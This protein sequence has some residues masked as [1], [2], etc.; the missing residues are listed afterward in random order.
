MLGGRRPSILDGVG[1]EEAYAGL[2]EN[3]RSV[4]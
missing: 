3:F 2:S 4:R 1:G